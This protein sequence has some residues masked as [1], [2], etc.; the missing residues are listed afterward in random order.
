MADRPLITIEDFERLIEAE[1]PFARELGVEVEDIG[2][3]TGRV[4]LPYQAHFARPGGSIN[5]PMIMATADF[6]MWVAIMSLW[7]RGDMA[8][9]ANMNMTFLRAPYECDLIGEGRVLRAGKR[10]A[11]LEVYV[12]GEGEEAPCAHVTGTYA[13]PS[14]IPVD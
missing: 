4:R 12:T 5:G 2:V 10:L 1:A 7:K 9:T 6:A 14:R 3:G 8:L 13:V 11:F